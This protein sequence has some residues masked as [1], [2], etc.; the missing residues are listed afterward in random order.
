MNRVTQYALDVLE[1]REI[2]GKYV[3]L[4]CQRHLDDLEKSKLAP[5]VYYF[6]EE[7]ADRLLEYAETLLIGEGEEVE[8]LILASFQAFI[9]GSLHGWVHKETGYRRFRSSYVQ[10]GRQNGKSM[11][12]GVLGTYYSNFDGYNYAQ[13]YCTATKQDQ[14]NI[15]LKEMIKFI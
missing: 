1:G 14:A 2:A 13:V 4:A 7:K 6:D 12:N 8:P 10:V 3:K 11:M 15:V 9:F 5:F